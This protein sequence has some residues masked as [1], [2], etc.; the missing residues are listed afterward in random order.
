[1]FGSRMLFFTPGRMVEAQ[2]KRD[3]FARIL[4]QQPDFHARI[5]AGD[6]M[7]RM[8]SDV[9]MIRLMFGFTILGII[10]T[11][12]AITLTATQMIRLSPLLAGAVTLPLL[13]GFAITLG[14]V[15]RFRSIMLRMQE[16]NSAL[17]DHVL[18]SYQGIATIKAF[19]AEGAVRERFAPLN[20]EALEAQL[21]R[22]RLRVGI[23]PILSLAA[24]FNIFLLLWIGGPMVMEQRLTVGQLIAFTTLVTYLTGPLR[25]LTFILSLFRQAQAAAERLDA[26]MRPQPLR[27]DL[28]GPRQAPTQAPGLRLQGLSYRYPGAGDDALHDVSVELAPR[29]TLGV[30][31]PTGSGKSTLLRCLARLNDPPAE[32][33]WVDGVDVRSI[34][35]DGWRDA[36]VLVPQRA[37]LFSESVSDNILLG[38]D[39]GSLEG[40]LQRAQLDVDMAALPHG[41]ASEVGEAGLTL[42]GG[43]RQRVALARGLAREAKLL[44]L[45]DVLSAVDHAT[46]A[47]LIEQLQ[48]QSDRPTTVIVAN[49]ISALRHADV[50]LVLERGRVVARGTHEALAEQPGIYREAWARQSDGEPVEPSP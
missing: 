40:L 8:S 43:Q 22:A 14:I 32:T 3:L 31:G 34:D 20:R 38:G 24:S 11:I 1:R 18:S 30:F 42:S 50:I 6:L 37:F 28:P 19:G 15:G 27:P 2:V 16:A 49:R 46:E 35:L 7:S 17:S 10:N 13:L 21:S 41:V 33:V 47:R 4:E 26:V 36:A 12:L 44:L 5:P 9:N 25:G 48:A 23:G 39:P 29:G 45:D